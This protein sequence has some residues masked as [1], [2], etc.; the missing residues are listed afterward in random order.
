MAE[1]KENVLDVSGSLMQAVT[2]DETEWDNVLICILRVACENTSY[3]Y[4]ICL[5][6]CTVSHT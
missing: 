1:D 5:T 3:G 6:I 4:P 2:R